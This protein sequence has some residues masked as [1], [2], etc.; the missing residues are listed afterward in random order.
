MSRTEAGQ[1]ADSVR[2]VTQRERAT[3]VGVVVSSTQSPGAGHGPGARRGSRCLVHAT[4]GRREGIPDGQRIPTVSPTRQRGAGTGKETRRLAP[5]AAV[6]RVNRCAVTT[7]RRH[8]GKGA[9]SAPSRRESRWIGSAA[10]R[11][12]SGE[13]EKGASAPVA[14]TV[15]GRRRHRRE[16]VRRQLCLEGGRYRPRDR[17]GERSRRPVDHDR[18]ERWPPEEPHH[19]RQPLTNAGSRLPFATASERWGRATSSG[20]HG[21]TGPGGGSIRTSSHCQVA[22][23]RS[24]EESA[25]PTSRA[26]STIG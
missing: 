4:A 7:R 21:R 9:G 15:V 19:D 25:E 3:L 5:S 13:D 16:R 1:V 18:R 26:T 8:G 12:R 22:A 17:F 11:R 2:F 14:R 6:A 20:K 10:R 23:A 24:E